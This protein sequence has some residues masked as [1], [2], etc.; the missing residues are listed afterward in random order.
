VH[1]IGHPS[2]E[3]WTYTTGTISQIRPN[4]EWTAD[5]FTHRSTVIQTQTA[6]NAGNSGGPLLNDEAE[7]IGINSFRREGEGLN[8]AVA[9]DTVEQF[10]KRAEQY[11]AP[12][13]PQP[14]YPSYNTEVYGPN[15]VGV[16]AST[17]VPPPDVWL[18]YEDPARTRLA[19][20]VKGNSVKTEIDIVIKPGDAAWNTL[21]HYWDADCDGRV[22]LVGYEVADTGTVTRYE[23]PRQPLRLES[24]AREFVEALRKHAIPYPNLRVCL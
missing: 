19:Y 12:S 13:S 16:Y 2:G 5:G 7:I 6:I 15:I 11:Q 9:A 23:Q 10:L 14:S 24:L 18:V 20:A 17:S 3:V 4:Y 1:A 8:Y 22:D 21:V